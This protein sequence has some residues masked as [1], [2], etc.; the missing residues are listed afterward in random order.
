MEPTNHT[1][2]ASAPATELLLG[3]KWRR[4]R[5][6]ARQCLEKSNEHYLLNLFTALCAASALIIMLVVGT[7][8]YWIYSSAMVKN[9]ETSAISVVRAIMSA[10]VDN[11]L[12]EGPDGRLVLA[13][14]NGDMDRLDAQMQRYL[15]FFSIHKIKLFTPDKTV[16]YSTNPG[17][18]GK[19]ADD[20]G[21][22]DR[23]LK[24][25]VASSKL[26][27]KYEQGQDFSERGP[28]WIENASIVEAQSPIFDASHRM[29]GVFEVYVDIT[30]TRDTIFD[31]LLLT[32][33]ALG[34]VLSACLF[35]LYLPMKRGTLRLIMAHREWT[36]LATR[37]YLTGAYNRR[38]IS[39]RAQQEFYRMRRG[40]K[41][42]R[43]SIS[44]I[45]ADIDCFKKINDSHGHIAGDEVLREVARR[46]KEGLRDI[47]VLCRYGGEEF[48][49]MCPQTDGL[50]AMI[51]AERLRQ[52]IIGMPVAIDGVGLISV[53]LS[54]GVA[55]SDDGTESEQAVIKRADQALFLAKERGRNAVVFAEQPGPAP[56]SGHRA[57][58][59][60]MAD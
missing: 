16:I 12:Q 31:V 59:E 4:W 10:E 20:D 35:S 56:H 15:K 42:A 41:L 47:D 57:P 60:L 9:A 43:E 55:S 30:K 50:G 46:L 6:R 33:T 45:M 32:M 34:A 51:V 18:I 27:S 5:H 39:A 28:A 13:V 3:K 38:Y 19:I 24:I 54:F 14:N 21:D 52:S 49:I 48:L 53:T 25:G 58:L 29:L 7:A 40:N 36:E 8:I 23:V 1:D 11:L 2:P 37:D 22:L 44:F 26:L 17:S